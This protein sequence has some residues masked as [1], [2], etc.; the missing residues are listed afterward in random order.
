MTD[1]YRMLFEQ[2]RERFLTY[3]QRAMIDWF[4]LEHDEDALY[5]RVLG[6]P[7]R[8]DRRTG[9]LVCGGREAGF[10]ESCAA[11]DILSRA[12]DRPVLAGR[13]VGIVDLGGNT[14]AHHVEHLTQDLSAVDGRLEEKKALCRSWGGAEQKQ[15]DLS[16]IVPLFDFFPV[17][18]QYWAGEEELDIPSKFKC[19]WDANTLD[20]MF[21]ETTWY[22]HGYLQARLTGTESAR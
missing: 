12:A 13:W 11:Y 22:A 21:Y 7:A 3:D 17:W 15:G 2:S 19:L 20:F 4:G 5:F 1:N 16:F 14:A 8:L 9:L 6:A 10:N 18:I